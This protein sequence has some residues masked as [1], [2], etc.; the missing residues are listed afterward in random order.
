LTAVEF[1]N[2]PYSSGIVDAGNFSL[3]FHVQSYT[4]RWRAVQ[5][6]PP[7]LDLDAYTHTEATSL[8]V[9]FNGTA[10]LGA[11]IVAVG[12]KT[13][14]PFAALQLGGEIP[15][16]ADVEFVGAPAVEPDDVIRVQASVSVVFAN[17]GDEDQD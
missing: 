2:R 11:S 17:F 6:T 10:V 3:D 5:G 16:I 9:P 8:I 15:L 1:A 4:V 7:G 12:M 13:S 14:P